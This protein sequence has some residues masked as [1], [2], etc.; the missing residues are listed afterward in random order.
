MRWAHSAVGQLPAACDGETNVKE[1]KTIE[2]AAKR[3]RNLRLVF[4]F[5]NIFL[6]PILAF[7]RCYPANTSPG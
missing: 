3:P 2:I 1:V 6:V 4:D 5:L 7:G